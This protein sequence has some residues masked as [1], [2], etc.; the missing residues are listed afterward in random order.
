MTTLMATTAAIGI[1][2]DEHASLPTDV[3]THNREL[4][5]VDPYDRSYED[6][7]TCPHRDRE[8][9]RSFDPNRSPPRGVLRG[10]PSCHE[11]MTGQFAMT[12][13]Y[14]AAGANGPL[15]GH[16]LC[17]M[18]RDQLFD[19]PLGPAGGPFEPLC[20]VSCCFECSDSPQCQ[21]WAALEPPPPPPPP[22]CRD[23]GDPFYCAVNMDFC[24]SS[25][26]HNRQLAD[27][28]CAHTC[29]Q[30]SP[31]EVDEGTPGASP[32]TGSPD[33]PPA[34]NTPPTDTTSLT[35]ER[36]I[37]DRTCRAVPGVTPISYSTMSTCHAECQSRSEANRRDPTDRKSVV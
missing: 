22:P 14:L 24:H 4:Q 35:F 18:Y 8:I 31:D 36:E 29:G 2:P 19:E 12:D 37:V 25:S 26:A 5:A 11:L 7:S 27:A 28:L 16:D 13:N 20:A 34:D 33:A 3:T 1:L 15:L 23:E 30:C 9:A 21:A 10:R 17:N 6:S 32:G